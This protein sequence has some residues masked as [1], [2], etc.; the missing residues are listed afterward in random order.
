METYSG[1]LDWIL[2]KA[3]RVGYRTLP[4]GRTFAFVELI[5]WLLYA[6]CSYSVELRCD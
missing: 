6:V 4:D 1:W 2:R 5:D 3:W